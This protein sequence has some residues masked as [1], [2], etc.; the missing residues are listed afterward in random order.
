MTLRIRF[1]TAAHGFTL[2]EIM[3]AIGVLGVILSMLASSFSIVAHGKVH[4]EGRLDANR[5]G[6]AVLWQMSSEI[7]G[8]VQ[9]PVALSHVL[10]I[11]NGRFGNN[12]PLDTITLS[13]LD[14]SHQRS[15]TGGGAESVISYNLV[16]NPDHNG[17]FLLQRTQQSG[18]LLSPGAPARFVLADNLLSLHIRY[19]DGQRWGESWDSSSLPRGRQLP[20]T[21]ALELRMAS[22][23][24]GG[25]MDYSTQVT[26]PMG[27]TQW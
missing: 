26:V 15:L 17:W 10:L 1:N 3:L 24:G 4:G 11:G 14:A 18:L 8:A 12:G 13:T 2:I 21:V 20:M 5:E 16:P 22:P 6:R 25:A 23:G 27:I 9:T 19:Y 7:R